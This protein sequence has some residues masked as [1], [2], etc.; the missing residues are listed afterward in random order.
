[1]VLH[2]RFVTHRC[3]LPSG[4]PEAQNMHQ[5]LRLVSLPPRHLC[6]TSAFRNKAAHLIY[7]PTHTTKMAK[8]CITRNSAVIVIL[9][10][11]RLFAEER[12]GR[13]W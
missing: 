5:A 7:Q 3:R 12:E 8:V 4:R 2:G 6:G 11:C 10:C 1:M 13:G 9:G